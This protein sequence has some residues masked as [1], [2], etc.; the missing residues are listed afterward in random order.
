M[1]NFLTGAVFAGVAAVAAAPVSAQPLH[2]DAGFAKIQPVTETVRFGGGGG[3]LRGGFGGRG[4]GGGF[5]GG[6]FGGRGYYGGGY[7]R[8]YY[9]RRYGYG[10]YGY[11][12][13]TGALLGGALAY[14]Y[15]YGGYYPSRS[16]YDDYDGGETVYEGG[17]GSSYCAR[18]FKSFDPRS[19]TYLGNDGR[20]HSCG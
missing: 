4:F 16:Y 11:G 8:G 14:P 15:Y 6:G 2:V 17:R 7:G 12:L 9:G 10:G 18:R 1:R 5:R 3:G 13:A 20:R 19:G